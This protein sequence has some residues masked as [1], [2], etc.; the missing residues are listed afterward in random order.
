MQ[1]NQFMAK[2][3]TSRNFAKNIQQYV[4]LLVRPGITFPELEDLY[5]DEYIKNLV[6]IQ[7][8]NHDNYDRD[9]KVMIKELFPTAIYQTN[10]PCPDKEWEG[11]MDLCDEFWKRNQERRKF[12]MDLLKNI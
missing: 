2:T 8:L 4:E 5:T 3:L 11:M 10:I 7:L 9:T 12:V 1:F 6:N